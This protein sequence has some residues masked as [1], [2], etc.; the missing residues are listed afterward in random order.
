MS[1]LAIYSTMSLIIPF[2]L[3][4]LTFF[5]PVA[6]NEYKNLV[7]KT[8]GL[9]TGSHIT[10]NMPSLFRFMISFSCLEERSGNEFTK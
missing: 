8:P 10:T 1:T 4:I 7:L 3:V 2:T 6:F 5:A 9:K